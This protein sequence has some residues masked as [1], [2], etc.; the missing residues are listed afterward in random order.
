MLAERDEELAKKKALI[1]EEEGRIAM[2]KLQSELREAEAKLL[3][4][5]QKATS[6]IA[7]KLLKFTK[8]G[9]GKPSYKQVEIMERPGEKVENGYSPG[10]LI[11]SWA[12]DEKSSELTR[13]HVTK[14]IDGADNVRESAKYEQRTFSL[15]TQ[16]N[17]KVIAFACD[18]E[19]TKNKWFTTISSA[20]ER[21]VKETKDM[22]S[23]YEFELIFDKRPLGFRVEERFIEDA[24]K[25]KK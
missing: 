2:L 19:D 17:N 11:I 15:E 24:N 18:T 3:A 20:L 13:A 25:N 9:K 1:K 14:L 10:Q 12:D 6:L 21:F 8:G 7:G 4:D 23:D 16:P 22:N 5:S